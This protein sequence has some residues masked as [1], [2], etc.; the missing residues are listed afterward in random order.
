MQRGF[1]KGRDMLMNLID[2]DFAAQCISIRSTRGA[3]IL[4]RG[5]LC[6]L[7]NPWTD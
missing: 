2:V 7:G 4:E 1:L 3:I 5:P 6:S